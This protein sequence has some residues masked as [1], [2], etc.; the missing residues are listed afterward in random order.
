MCPYKY[1]KTLLNQL[2][3]SFLLKLFIFLSQILKKGN[4]NEC[5]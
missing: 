2:Q 1:S 5:P 3:A 4:A